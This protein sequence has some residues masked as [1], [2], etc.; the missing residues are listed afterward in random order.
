[1]TIE[2]RYAHDYELPILEAEGWVVSAFLG[3]RGGFLTFLLVRH[4]P[5]ETRPPVPP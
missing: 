1:M 4:M 3:E 2:S 5:T